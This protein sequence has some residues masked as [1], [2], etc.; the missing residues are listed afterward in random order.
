MRGVHRPLPCLVQPSSHHQ[1]TV[2]LTRPSTDITSTATSYMTYSH[3]TL[4]TTPGPTLA[5][6]PRPSA[7]GLDA[8]VTRKASLVFDGRR[9]LH[10]PRETPISG[11]TAS[12]RRPTASHPS[13]LPATSTRWVREDPPF[14]GLADWGVI[15][16]PSLARFESF[17]SPEDTSLEEKHSFL[18][19]TAPLPIRPTPARHSMRHRDR[20]CP[21]RHRRTLTRSTPTWHAKRS[22]T[23]VTHSE[24]MLPQLDEQE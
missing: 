8:N 7:G 18:L 24:P 21:Q 12:A 20:R 22:H 9:C 11:T 6:T 13:G 15:T 1:K 19:S 16:V 17:P 2:T 4:E 10:T 3:S 5:R 14:A 23:R